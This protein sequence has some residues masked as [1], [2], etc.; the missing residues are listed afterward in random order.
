MDVEKLNDVINIVT[1]S[2]KADG[3]KYIE[4]IGRIDE[5]IFDREPLKTI[6][7][8]NISSIII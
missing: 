3:Y 8:S 4:K 2:L 5:T 1:D 7:Y 6:C